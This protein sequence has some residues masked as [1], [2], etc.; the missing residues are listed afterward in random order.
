MTT[1]PRPRVLSGITPSGALT[2]GNH[3]GALQRFVAEQD[4]Q[5]GFFFV[6]DL[7]AMTMPHE[8]ARLRRLTLETAALFFAA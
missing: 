6:A 1:E 2:L 7:H 8:P 5:D 3:L 4:H